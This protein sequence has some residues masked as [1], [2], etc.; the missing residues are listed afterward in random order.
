MAYSGLKVGYIAHVRT[1]GNTGGETRSYQ[2]AQALAAR[3]CQVYL[4]AK[5][6]P[7]FSWHSLVVSRKLLAPTNRAIAQLHNELTR[8]NVDVGIERYQF[9]LFNAGFWAQLLRRKPIVLEVHGFPIDEWSLM[10]RQQPRSE[11]SPVIRLL[12]KA[13]RRAWSTLQSFVFS[14]TDHFVV[15]SAGTKSILE[16]L[17]VVPQCVSVIYNRVDT[18]MFNPGRYSLQRARED[19]GFRADETVLLYA[20][21]LFHE[22]LQLVVEAFG[23]ILMHV[24]RAR[25]VLFGAGGSTRLLEETADRLHLPRDKFS[26]SSAIPHTEMPRLLR[27]ADVVLAPYT[28]DSERFRSA[29]HF[30]PLKIMEALSMAKPVVTVNAAELRSV[31]A[32]LDNIV[33]V[34]ESTCAAWADA[35]RTAIK[36][37]D[38]PHLNQGRDFVID[39]YG[40]EDAAR[41]YLRIVAAVSNG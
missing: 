40:W 36:M 30:S 38:D 25:M 22:E 21:S 7:S 2:V 29:F 16:Q 39:G 6:D 13:P 19:F 33:F 28:L 18:D 26:I 41:E 14:H 12:M 3:R 32:G 5:P 35:M 9:P 34:K 24:P 31:F 11:I 8:A 27:A 37:R 10:L 23:Q 1:P 15:T 17:G 4:Y 20:G